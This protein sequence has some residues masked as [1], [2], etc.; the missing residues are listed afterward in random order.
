MAATSLAIDG[1]DP[2]WPCRPALRLTK[3]DHLPVRPADVNTNLLRQLDWRQFEVFCRALLATDG[4]E[5]MLSAI[6]PDGGIDI[7]IVDERAHDTIVQCK[8]L[9]STAYLHP[10]KVREFAYVVMREGLS[11][12]WLMTTGRVSERMRQE[13]KGLISILTAPEIA[14]WLHKLTAGE[15]QHI[16]NET[17][18]GEWNVQTCVRCRAKRNEFHTPASCWGLRT[19][20]RSLFVQS[21]Q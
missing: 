14:D 4:K 5:P 11:H 15:R 20:T 6:G 7:R 9:R 2:E 19:R 8:H 13:T 3:V 1:P 21:T 12:G 16:V 10:S 18:V 17:F